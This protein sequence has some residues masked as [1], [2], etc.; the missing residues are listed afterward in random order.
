MEA[1]YRRIAVA[2]KNTDTREHDIADSDDYYQYHGGM[3]ATVRALTGTRAG[4]LR[5]RLDAPRGRPHPHPARGDLPRVPRPRGQP[6]LD[7][8]HAPARLQG[9]VRD[10]RHRRLPVR[11]GRHHRRDR[12]L[13][14]REAHRRATCSTPSTGSS[15][16]TPTRGRC[17][18][19]P[20][21]CWRPSTAGCGR[22]PEAATLDAL[23]QAY[24]ETEGR[25][26][27]RVTPHGLRHRDRRGRPRAPDPA[28]RRGDEPRRRVLH[29]RQGRGDGRPRRAARRAA[30]AGTSPGPH[31][32]VDGAGGPA[33]DRDPAAYVDTRDRAGR[34]RRRR[35][36]RR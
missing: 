33:R 32:V 18:A 34:P 7:G 3:I 14:V 28:G 35:S 22:R 9:R 29:D 8:G 25:P 16:P 19:W 27:G 13:A 12:R 5:R 26:G 2:A 20:S 4:G 17:T 24:L 15:S 23:R 21:G 36:T 10:G 11:L 31:R 1:A 30:G 6:A